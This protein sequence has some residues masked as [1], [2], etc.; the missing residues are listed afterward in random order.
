M[1]GR[2]DGGVCG[3]WGVGVQWTAIKHKVR[4]SKQRLIK[5]GYT[6]VAIDLFWEVFVKLLDEVV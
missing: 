2:W 6:E 4:E 1:M 5:V 3:A